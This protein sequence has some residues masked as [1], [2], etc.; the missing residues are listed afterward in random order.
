MKR[1]P[2][3]LVYTVWGDALPSWSGFRDEVGEYGFG[4]VE[5]EISVGYMVVLNPRRDLEVI[6]IYPALEV[7]VEDEISW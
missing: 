3:T 1:K 5:M 7:V 4:D 2:N 6:S